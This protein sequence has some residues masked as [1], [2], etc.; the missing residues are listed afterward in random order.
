MISASASSSS[1]GLGFVDGLAAALLDP[2]PLLV[3]GGSYHFLRGCRSFRQPLRPDRPHGVSRA[4]ATSWYLATI[5]ACTS[6]LRSE[7]LQ[8]ALST[9]AKGASRERSR[10]SEVIGVWWGAPRTHPQVGGRQSRRQ[11]LVKWLI[12]KPSHAPNRL[13]AYPCTSTI[14]T[15]YPCMLIARSLLWL[16]DRFRTKHALRML[17][18]S[19]EK[20]AYK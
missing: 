11:S 2:V 8:N 14:G 5:S 18:L 4:S 7:A 20:S 17:S 9:L 15:I 12:M 1:S 19:P 6:R 3:S 16:Q 10:R 13:I